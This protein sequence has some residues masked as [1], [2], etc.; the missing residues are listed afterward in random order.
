[1]RQHNVPNKAPTVISASVALAGLTVYANG[2]SVQ[3]HIKSKHSNFHF[4]VVNN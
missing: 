1:M 3:D 2:E 4:F